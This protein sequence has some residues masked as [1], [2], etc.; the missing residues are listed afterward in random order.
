MSSALEL[1]RIRIKIGTADCGEVLTDG[2]FVD[3]ATAIA[4][5]KRFPI[6]PNS[7]IFTL[8]KFKL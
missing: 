5:E 6:P 7:T 2:Q 4:E 8:S 3:A 1:D